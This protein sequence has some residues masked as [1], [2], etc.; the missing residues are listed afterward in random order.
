MDRVQAFADISLSALYA[1]ALYTAISLHTCV[2]VVIA[3]KSVHSA[4]IA[5]P[6]NSTQLETPTIPRSYIRVRAVVWECDEGQ[7]YTQ[8]AVA[9]CI[10]FSSAMPHAKC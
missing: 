5:N 4:P 6:P 9:N 3:T 8:T 1:F 2:C 7:T 10:H